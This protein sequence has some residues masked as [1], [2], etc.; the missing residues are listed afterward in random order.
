MLTNMSGSNMQ[1]PTI[2]IKNSTSTAL[3]GDATFTGDWEP[4]LTSFS[5]IVVAVKTDVSGTLYV[6]LSP[7]GV[8]IDSTLTFNITAGV[9]EPPHRIVLT[10]RYARVRYVNGSSAQSYMRLQTMF[11]YHNLLSSPLN[12]FIAQD[13]DAI[14]VRNI[15]TETTIAEG[16]IEGYSIVNK[17]GRNTDISTGTV[18]EGVWGGGGTYTGWATA[19]ETIQVLSSSANDTAAGSGARTIRVTGLDANYNVQNET[20]TLNGTTPVTSTNTFIRVHTAQITTSGSSNTAFNAGTITVRQSTTT[21]N[22]FLS[23]AIGTNQ[24]NCSAY[25]VPA[26]YTGYMRHITGAIRGG[27]NANMNGA[28]YVKANGT[29]APRLR[30]PFTINSSFVLFDVI[31]GGLVFTEK[32][33]II[34]RITAC[35]G[36]SIEVVGGYDLILVKN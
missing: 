11:G 18:P 21:A 27:S 28:V 26:G 30:R 24:T 29:A 19:A 5:S 4:N 7:D 33:D 12:S 17:F 1:E 8:N 20:L 3:A 10:R 31:Y 9:V 13:A 32:T 35:S 6:D 22:V 2:S 25:T 15:D 14:M 34:L 16:R 36:N 23:M